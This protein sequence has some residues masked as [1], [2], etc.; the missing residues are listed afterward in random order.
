MRNHTALI[1][2]AP[3][4]MRWVTSGDGGNRDSTS[5]ASWNVSVSSTVR[6]LTRRCMLNTEKPALTSGV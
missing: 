4:A 2:G 6:S 1:A 3:G 5:T